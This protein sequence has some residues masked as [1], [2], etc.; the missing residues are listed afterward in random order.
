MSMGKRSDQGG[1]SEAPWRGAVG[2]LWGEMGELQLQFLVS[3]GLRRDH[4]F[5]DVGC[6]SFRAGVHLVRYLEAGKYNGIDAQQ[7][8]LDAGL[9]HEI[10]RHGLADRAPRVL[11]RD[12][13]DFSAF[14]TPFDYAIA[15]S[16]FT[17]VPWN[18]ILRC[19]HNV[20]RVL[21]PEGQFFATFFEDPDGTH[22]TTPLAHQP[23]GVTT[24]T[25]KDPF[26]YQFDVFVELAARTRLEATYVGDWNHPRGQKMMRFTRAA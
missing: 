23:G 19:L 4:R 21:T 6:G 7:W 20:R 15:Q 16:V 14:G 12:D 2:G 13:F 17:H 22:L 1:R 3:Q 11:C 24:Y 25:D 10:G 18:T 26:H 5:L 9:E 8:L